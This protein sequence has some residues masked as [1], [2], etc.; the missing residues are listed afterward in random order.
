MQVPA[1]VSGHTHF[2]S[3]TKVLQVKVSDTVRYLSDEGGGNRT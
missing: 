3:K 2:G 1:Q